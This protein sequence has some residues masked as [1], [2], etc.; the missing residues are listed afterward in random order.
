MILIRDRRCRAGRLVLSTR[1][2][3]R[4]P[5]KTVTG[6]GM[7]PVKVTGRCPN[8]EERPEQYTSRTDKEH[9]GQFSW[10]EATIRGIGSIK[11]A[12]QGLTLHND[13]L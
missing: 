11:I 3:P 12:L 6:I 1:G 4:G 7:K 5:V 9:P 8:E 2:Y 13:G 10:N